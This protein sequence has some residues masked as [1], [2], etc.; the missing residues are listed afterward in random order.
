M[1]RRVLRNS[2]AVGTA[3]LIIAGTFTANAAWAKPVPDLPPEPQFENVTVHDPS[4]VTAGDDI[5]VFGSHGASAHTERPA[6][7]GAAHRRPVAEPR[8]RALR[9]RLHRARRDLRVGADAHAVGGRCHPAA[10]RP[11]RHVLQRVRGQL[12]AFGAR[13]RDIRCRRRTVRESGHPPQERHGRRVR[14]SRRDLR[15]TRPPEHRRPRRVLRR[16]G[17]PLDGLRLVLG[18]H[19]HPR[20]RPGDGQP[21]PGQGY[22]THLVGRQPQPDRSAHHPVRRGQRLLLPLPLVRRAGCRRRLR[23]ARGPVDEPR[24][25]L[26]RR[27]RAT[28]WPR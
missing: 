9:G 27:G 2:L 11:V 21:L 22:G 8:Q 12:A 4:V 23:R 7:L 3:G 15:R 24:R 1:T 19:L 25:P 10:R 16:R 14:E 20:A 6:E 28:T 13:A 17:Q 5:W 18:R 26:P